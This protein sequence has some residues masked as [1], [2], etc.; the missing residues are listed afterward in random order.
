MQPLRRPMDP[1]WILFECAAP[2]VP[3]Q[4]G[5]GGGVE[6]LPEAAIDPPVTMA[7]RLQREQ[8]LELVRR[9]L[10]GLRPGGTIAARVA[11]PALIPGA[12]TTPRKSIREEQPS[13][14]NTLLRLSEV[15]TEGGALCLIADPSLAEEGRSVC[16]P[17]PRMSQH[18]TAVESIF[19]GSVSDFV[20]PAKLT[21]ISYV[22]KCW[23]L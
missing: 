3:R 19:S 15:A 14:L 8:A 7:N 4:L 16:V 6:R 18:R 10:P 20:C 17:C 5:G 2:C 22:K 12:V 21:W 23:T 1:F 13:L 11:A 9:H